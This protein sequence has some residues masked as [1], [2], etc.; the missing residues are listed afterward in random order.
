MKRNAAYMCF[1]LQ[2]KHI[3]TI[4]GYLGLTG[5][6]IEDIAILELVEPFVLSATLVPVCIDL[7]SDRRVLEAG[8]QGKVAGFGRTADGNS[9]AILQTL[10][11]PYIPFSQC[12]SA[13]QNANTQKY[14]T[15]DKFCAGYTNG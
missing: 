7:F 8:A 3:Y 15:P 11:V 1:L 12:N 6:Y 5:N 10:T 13:T 14:L 4:C 9:S 2:V